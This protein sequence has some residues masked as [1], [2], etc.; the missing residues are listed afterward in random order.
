[1]KDLPRWIMAS[2][3]DFFKE[4][5]HFPLFFEHTGDKTLKGPITKYAEFRLDGPFATKVTKNETY[6]DI[7]INILCIATLNESYADDLEEVLGDFMSIFAIG[8]FHVFRYGDHD[9]DDQSK[10]GCMILSTGKHE[11]IRVSRFGQANPD[12]RVLQAS[13]EAH[14]QMRL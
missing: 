6:Y 13:V 8:W 5:S 10:V 4:N 12:T 3:R 1:M 11:E 2:A 14:Y 7:E 9:V